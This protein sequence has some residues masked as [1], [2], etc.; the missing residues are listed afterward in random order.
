MS[1]ELEGYGVEAVPRSER[2][3]NWFSMFAMYAGINI[4]LPMMLVGGLLVP[5]ISFVEAALVG[6]VSCLIG[7]G[8]TCLA[9]YP[10]FEHGV[11]VSVQ[12][13]V[14]LGYPLGTWIP[15][16]AIVFSLVGWFAVQT[17]LAAAAADGVLQSTTGLSA[18]LLMTLLVGGANVYFAVMGYGWIAR[19]ASIAVPALLVLCV[20]LFVKIGMDQPFL[21]LITRPGTGTLSF[22]TALNIMLSGQIAGAFTASDIARYAR[23]ARSVWGGVLG[24]VTPVTVF[25]MLLGALSALSS[26]EWN[27]VLGVQS[28]GLGVGAL[29]LIVFATWTTNDKNLYSGGLA[30][31]NLFPQRPRWQL[32][33]LLGVIGTFIAC[34]RLTQYFTE[35]LVA[36]GIVFAPLVS[37]LVTDY[38]LIRRRRLDLASLSRERGINWIAVL[39]LPLGAAAG[40]LAPPESVQPVI[41]MLV[42]GGV[43]WI[44]MQMQST[45]VKAQEERK[46]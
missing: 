31:T 40:Q 5:G 3:Q 29:L 30:L 10:G 21:E 12:S 39:A 28:L 46:G 33:L 16:A 24:G 15:S 27:P 19:L 42:T 14:W 26:G 20:A 8:M 34:L 44:G 23:G 36:L 1:L 32:T 38:F 4:C 11:T 9:A 45:I 13:R 18:P 7:F 22:L 43:Y 37:I 35:W 2:T 41:A 6:L 17:E 25:M